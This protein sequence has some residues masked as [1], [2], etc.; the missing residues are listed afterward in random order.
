MLFGGWEGGKNFRVGIFLSEN[1]FVS[2]WLQE[3]NK[4]FMPYNE[5]FKDTNNPYL[6]L[7][8]QSSSVG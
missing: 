1:L 7:G 6:Y 4:S 5:N 3:T 2:V 8:G